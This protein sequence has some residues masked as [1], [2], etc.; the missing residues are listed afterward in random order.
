[1][2]HKQLMSVK[3]DELSAS[4]AS[5][6][7]VDL[8]A[9]REALPGGTITTDTADRL[10]WRDSKTRELQL[11]LQLARLEAALSVTGGGSWDIDFR[12]GVA[13]H[14][15]A[16]Y[17]LFGVDADVGRRESS[18]WSQRVHPEDGAVV[19][20]AVR[21]RLPIGLDFHEAEYR[22][23]HADQQWRW[24]LDRA[25]V[26]ERDPDG[27][28]A[29]LIGLLVDITERKL[30]EIALSSSDQRFRTAAQ[31]VHG[32]VYETDLIT[33][34]VTRVGVER[35]LGYGAEEI[36][37]DADS[38]F[39]LY[40]PDEQQ[41]VRQGYAQYLQSGVWQGG[42]YRV[43]HRDGHYVT[44]WESPYL[45]R[46]LAGKPIRSI[47]FVI[48]ITK[49]VEQQERLADSEQLFRTAAALTPGFVW[50]GRFD[51]DGRLF[52]TRV[53]EGFQALIGCTLEEFEQSG[54][55]L[56]QLFDQSHDVIGTTLDRLRAGA[57]DVR[58]EAQLRRPDGERRWLLMRGQAVVDPVSRQVVGC[59]GSTEDV[60]EKRQ[61][62]EALRHSQA[63]LMTIAQ[64]SADWLLLVDMS[65]KILFIN[66]ALRGMEPEQIIG[67]KIGD[68]SQPGASEY[69]TNLVGE[70]LSK[71]VPRDIEQV[72]H[73]PERGR[74]VFELR[75]RPV[76]E[77]NRIAGAVINATE[78]TRR[79][80]A[81]ELRETQA[82]MLETLSEA[83]AMVQPNGIIRLANASFDRL[84][85]FAAGGAVGTS[86]AQLIQVVGEE[87]TSVVARLLREAA[88]HPATTRAERECMRC[89]G[90]VF[91]A[92]VA[93]AGIQL[94]AGANWLVTF[95]DVT[96]RKRMEREILE[97]ANREQ[98]RI[99]SDLH[100]G[101][102]Q[103]LTGIALMLRGVAVQLR[104]E[105]S[106]VQSEVEEVISLVNGAI[107]NTRSLARGLSP[108]GADRGGLISALEAMASHSMERYGVRT[109]LTTHLTEPLRLDDARAS[110]LYRIAQEALTNAVRH[111]RVSEVEIELATGGGQLT[112]MIRD[113]GRGLQ[114][115]IS[116]RDG[117]GLKLMRY[118][119]QMVEGTLEVANHP[120]GGLMVRCTCPHRVSG[121][122][123]SR[124]SGGLPLKD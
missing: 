62:E 19:L 90:E 110:H 105:D 104:K 74:R 117:M 67:R 77:G 106:T 25:R 5:D 78:I 6:R 86:L 75:L 10:P 30:R 42:P 58:I 68:A 48:D 46:D 71:G 70:V 24:V 27:R 109:L 84:F 76:K 91:T 2:R 81:D 85:G 18:F 41:L 93:A 63:Q 59:M 89:D 65:Q 22:V 98:L 21:R 31:A 92:S 40:H 100:D 12:T 101:L 49:Q 44:L 97:I 29:R 1:M 38:W 14:S 60:T 114:V 120:N 69:M 94:A 53:S 47:G 79:R 4:L 37:S 32:I 122:S 102:G 116:R 13:Q 17:R 88:A 33:G 83:V 115:P 39:D 82:R 57:V 7:V 73:D 87:E 35:V 16:Y 15:D 123:T 45:E 61:S 113:D 56:G 8:T 51:A 66:R 121:D 99:G 112:L 50:Q 118:R 54:G 20:E 34:H 43:R 107:E 3:S 72:Y 36:P 11:E 103:D 26:A 55:C 28:P 23:L 108:V 95:T 52:L 96:E 9:A 124:S 80:E 119:A 64:T 111:G